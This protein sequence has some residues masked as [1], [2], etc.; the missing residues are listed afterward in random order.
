M[1]QATHSQWPAFDPLLVSASIALLALGALMVGSASISLADRDA[2]EPFYYLTRHVAALGLGA[3]AAA[4][5]IAMP[6][7]VWDRLSWTLLIAAMVLLTLVLVP[8]FG[9]T[10]NGSSRWL[11]IG[12]LRM[13]PSEPARL[14]VLLYLS[15]YVLRHHIELASSLAG[16]VKPMLIVGAAAA[17][18]LAEPD[19]G[20]AV[21]LCATS[22]GVLFV[23][24]ARLRNF[25]LALLLAGAALAALAFSSAY[26]VERMTAFLDPWADPFASGFQLTQ[27]LIAIGRGDWFGVG[28][29][30]SVQKLFYLPEAH[31]DFVF[32]VLAEELGFIGATAVILLYA[33]LVY[34]A[35]VLGR[36]AMRLGLPF[37]GL[38][39]TGIGLTLGLEAF[40]NIGVNTGL[41]PTKG[42]TLPLL[43]YGRSSMVVTMFALGL[44]IRIH[45]EV[46]RDERG[47]RPGRGGAA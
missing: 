27:S 13:Q 16:F 31:T 29:G 23:G 22:L 17:L 7:Q 36:H 41:L 2:G 26:R 19:F 30:A 4:L 18:L 43:S 8:E 25:A 33:A 42:L 39:A 12:P 38:V 45:Y 35:I 10:V 46:C 44:L 32:A 34:R 1:R 20:A 11:A 24:G 3:A 40:I 37:Q 5:A 6:M 9:Q 47:R 21:V 28:L 14:C 15:S